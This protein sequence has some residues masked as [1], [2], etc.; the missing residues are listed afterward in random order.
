MVLSRKSRWKEALTHDKQA[1][2]SHCGYY[3][4][5]ARIYCTNMMMNMEE[6]RTFKFQRNIVLMKQRKV[7]VIAT[8]TCIGNEHYTL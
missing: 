5:Q 4:K 7:E 8:H 3:T 2:N 1:L 6:K